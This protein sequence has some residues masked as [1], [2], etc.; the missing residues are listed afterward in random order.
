MGRIL[1][2]KEIASYHEAGHIFSALLAERKDRFALR[3]HSSHV[4]ENS[5]IT[6]T[7]GRAMLILNKE[8]GCWHKNDVFGLVCVLCAGEVAERMF[9]RNPF[10]WCH[11]LCDRMDILKVLYR[12][13]WIPFSEKLAYARRASRSVERAFSRPENV[14]KIRLIASALTER[15]ELNRENVLTLLNL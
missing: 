8:I 9:T 10:V 5:C 14:L 2:F 11:A 12:S 3:F 4:S 6:Y 7:V 1:S 13:K 15:S